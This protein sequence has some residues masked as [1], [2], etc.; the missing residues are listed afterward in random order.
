MRIGR[1]ARSQTKPPEADHRQRRRDQEQG[2]R[3][4]RPRNQTLAGRR[5]HG[6]QAH[7]DWRRV[8]SHNSTAAAASNK[9]H[10][11]GEEI[12]FGLRARC[13]PRSP[14]VQLVRSVDVGE[15]IGREA[16]TSPN[17]RA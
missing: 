12:A 4:Q 13:Q 9:R 2:Q 16:S 6:G 17:G 11:P 8:R 3:A 10:R 15:Q 1:P 7:G 5:I 14:E